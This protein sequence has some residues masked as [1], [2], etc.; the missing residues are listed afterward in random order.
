MK[1]L[2][3]AQEK[4]I[5]KFIPNHEQLRART[6]KVIAVGP[7]SKV[8]ITPLVA[9]LVDL[10]F[11]LYRAYESTSQMMEV[12]VKYPDIKP[13]NIIQNFDRCKYIVLA[14]DSNAYMNLI[15]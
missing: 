11:Q 8:E 14:L 5:A 7:F 15:G 12:R 4:F 1:K 13:T 6:E 3:S 9:A 2:T 10:T